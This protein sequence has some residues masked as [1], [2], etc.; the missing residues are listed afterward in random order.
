[1]AQS[2][3]HPDLARLVRRC[4]SGDARAW[5]ILVERFA[6]LVFSAARRVGLKN[7]DAEDV[8]Q[9]VFLKLYQNLDRIETPE[10]LGGWLAVTATREAI[11]VKK[12]TARTVNV[13]DEYQ[14]LEE[15]LAADEAMADKLATVSESVDAITEA[16]ASLRDRCRELL[17]ALYLV[18]DPSYQEISDRLEIPIGSIGPTRARCIESLRSNLAKSGY[19]EGV[20]SIGKDSHSGSVER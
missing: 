12:I 8:S 9:A 6:N 5:D 13:A 1:M 11:R 15:T 14:G 17:T 16:I 19:F 7:E 10:A 2:S 20:V 18:D 4:R 3:S